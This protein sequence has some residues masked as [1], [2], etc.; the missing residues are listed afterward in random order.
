M[1]HFVCEYRRALPHN[2]MPCLHRHD[3]MHEIYFLASGR[4]KYFAGGSS[5]S[6]CMG[7]FVFIRSG[8]LHRTSYVD[9]TSHSRYYALIPDS[10]FSDICSMLPE[11]FAS[12]R[13][14][15]L[16]LYF[17]ELARESAKGDCLSEFRARALSS[18]IISD[19]LMLKNREGRE[20]D[21]VDD[22]LS[23]INSNLDGD[24]SLAAIS[25]SFGF[26]PNYFSS[27]FH[28]R[29]GITLSDAIKMVRIEKACELL[30][31]TSVD[32]ASISRM[33]GFSDPGYFSLVFRSQM[34]IS[35]FQY[36]KKY[37]MS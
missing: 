9:D 3:G 34:K 4:R 17:A 1:E 8:V 25:S 26:A 21:L 36:R 33:C 15:R 13:A 7:D 24:L 18:L 14:D 28:A 5:Y 30:E 6:I 2:E 19:A 27:M 12:Y 37:N 16:E 23:F 29:A 20:K 11:S 32:I 35:P 10:W 22:V 31:N